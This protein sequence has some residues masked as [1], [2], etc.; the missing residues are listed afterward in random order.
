MN[1]SQMF[2]NRELSWIEFNARVLYE[3]IR[4]DIPL[5]ERFKF[6]S[7][8]SSNFDEFFMVRVAG[9]KRQLQS[10][11][12]QKDISGLTVQE[13]LKLISNR[14]HQVIEKQHDVLQNEILPLLAE[15]NIVYVKPEDYTSQQQLF[16]QTMFQNEILPLLT[17][18]RT[19]GDEFPHISNLKLHVAFRLTP[20]TDFDSSENIFL[21]KDTENPIAIVQIPSSLSRIV[22]LPSTENKKMFTLLDDIVRYYGTALFPG[23]GI[24]ES[25]LFKV[26][27]DADF[28]V[29]E[30]AN[31]NFIQEM[32]KVLEK[33][34]SSFPVQLLC[35]KSSPKIL[36]FLKIKQN[37]SDDDVYEIKGII[38]PSTLLPIVDFKESKDLKYP[39]WN[40]FYPRDFIKGEKL[41]DI[42]KQ[43]DILLHV[44]YQSYDPVISLLNDAAEDSETLAIKMTLYRTSGNSPVIRALEKAA[45]NGKQVTVFLELKARFDEKQN[46]SWAA[47]LQ[48]AGVTVV[49]GI[50]NLKVHGKVLLVIRR[51]KD[52][53]RRYVHL[54]TGNYN[55]KTAKFYAD[56]SLFTTNPEI[57]DDVTF[58]FNSICG[59]S[60]IYPMKRLIMAPINLKSKLLELIDREI[61][62]STPEMPG[63]IMA[64]M[65]S[66]GHEEII[67]AL[68][69]ASCAG[70][71]ILL[72][73]RGICMLVPGVKNQS[74][75]IHVVSIIDRYLEH[76]RI[77]YFQN[78]GSPE[79]YLSS[80]DWMPRNLDRRVELMFPVMQEDLFLQIKH[81]LQMY[82]EDNTHS[83]KLNSDGSWSPVQPRDGDK[84]IAVQE[85]FYREYKNLS[86]INDKNI[87]L[88][89]IVRR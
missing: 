19:D 73:I 20:L 48:K 66:L 7:I 60:V 74:E 25:L 56:M 32:E 2:F 77:F 38:D 4:N 52:G 54:S 11:V 59:Y 29:N 61:K 51:E 88:E 81:C 17:P 43:K 3:A 27:R 85:S 35:C 16:A 71:N 18:L 42:L 46:I 87:S 6:L 83:H 34:Q 64:K 70:V 44:P 62:V 58:F 53:I 12:N 68:Y 72:N 76:S 9:L 45:R 30:D 28:A 75:N 14:A 24:V 84:K 21:P 33:R 47:Q 37:L 67:Q 31:M 57:I 69:R 63:L 49:Q 26:T 22:S 8:V 40:H 36:E 10:S 65:N 89:F 5:I 1:S 23:Y 82:F 50:V 79:I 41:W 86:E 78:A 15:N 55:D 13:Q 80:A 39:N